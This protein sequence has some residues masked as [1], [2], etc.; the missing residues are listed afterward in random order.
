ML[1]PR[2]TS[3]EPASEPIVSL[4]PSANTAPAVPVTADESESRF[5]AASES[6]PA[7]T[8]VVPVMLLA[9]DSVNVPLPTFV[10]P[11]LPVIEPA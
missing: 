11:P 2:A 1:E 4:P 10:K 3:N 6:R 7:L 5:A 8:V 9:A